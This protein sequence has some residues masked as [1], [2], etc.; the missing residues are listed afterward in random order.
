MLSFF[1]CDSE[2]EL[3]RPVPGKKREG[4]K[5]KH[6]MSERGARSQLTYTNPNSIFL[7]RFFV[8]ISIFRFD[9]DFFFIK[10]FVV[11]S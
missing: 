5:I 1:E 4:G 3:S 8:S 7:Y 10:N 6:G 2:R 11:H 9:F